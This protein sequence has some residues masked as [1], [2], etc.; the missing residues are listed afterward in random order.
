MKYIIITPAYNEEKYIRYTLDSVVNQTIKPIQWIIVN[1]GSTDNTAKI[2]EEYTNKYDWIKLINKSKSNYLFGQNVVKLFY[3][4]LEN[5]SIKDYDYLMKLDADLDIDSENYIN[6]QL[7]KFSKEP[8]LGICSGITYYYFNN[9]KIIEMHP[10]WR[11]TGAMKFYRKECFENIGGLIP[12]LGWDG[13]DEY[14]A[15]YRGWKTKTFFNLEVNHL[16]KIKD[17]KRKKKLGIFLRSGESYYIRGYSFIFVILKSLKYLINFHPFKGFCVIW[18]YVCSFLRNKEK[19]V[20]KNEAKF[21]RKFQ[22]K[23]IGIFKYFK[24]KK[25]DQNST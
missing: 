15:M 9:K 16:G 12:I 5:C 24:T 23:R 13:I 3:Y 18:G 19:V 22:Y 2:V 17:I 8:K 11:T 4:G 10:K 7:K 21:V 6:Y 1:D 25:I 14:K 20:S